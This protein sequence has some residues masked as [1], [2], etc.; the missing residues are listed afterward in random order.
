MAG[1]RAGRQFQERTGEVVQRDLQHIA[2]LRTGIV[3]SKKLDSKKA[4]K[5][6]RLI[7]ELTVELLAIE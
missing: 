7:D 3:L 1:H 6:V 5:I 2:R 4:A